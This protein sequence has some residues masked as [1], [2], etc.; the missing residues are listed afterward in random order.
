MGG[1]QDVL[2]KKIMQ[3]FADANLPMGIF[4]H[5]QKGRLSETEVFDFLA[6]GL[7]THQGQHT[8]GDP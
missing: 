2:G 1:D 8:H 6:H 7:R 4:G 3:P 5:N